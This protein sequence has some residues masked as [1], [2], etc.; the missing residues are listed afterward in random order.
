LV[1]KILQ[2]NARRANHMLVVLFAVQVVAEACDTASA[3]DVVFDAT[4][5]ADPSGRPLQSLEWGQDLTAGNNPVLAA[6]VNEVR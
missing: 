5:C 4:F 6:V 2:R 3:A 1:V